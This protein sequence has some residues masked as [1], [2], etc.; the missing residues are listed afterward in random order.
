M[1]L[2]SIDMNFVRKI[3]AELK[4]RGMARAQLAQ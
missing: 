2:A 4:G 3:L 1:M